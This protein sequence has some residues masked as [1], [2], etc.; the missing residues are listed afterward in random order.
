M[1]V[2]LQTH[3]HTTIHQCFGVFQVLLFRSFSFWEQTLSLSLS[4]CKRNDSLAQ[5]SHFL[6]TSPSSLYSTKCADSFSGWCVPTSTVPYCCRN[7]RFAKLNYLFILSSLSLSVNC[8]WRSG[9][10]VMATPSSPPPSPPPPPSPSALM[11]V[12]VVSRLE[13][14]VWKTIHFFFVS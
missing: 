5:G 1:K 4:A 14:I 6:P 7:Q 10:F 11:L 13:L 12:A 8:S 2:K 3:A 9:A